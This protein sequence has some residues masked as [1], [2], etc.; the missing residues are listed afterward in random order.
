M[1]HIIFQNILF[2]VH[3]RTTST[4]SF[5]KQRFQGFID[6]LQFTNIFWDL[7]AINLQTCALAA[8]TKSK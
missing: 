8:V 4:P 3:F 1:Q 2:I 5:C 6:T 7:L